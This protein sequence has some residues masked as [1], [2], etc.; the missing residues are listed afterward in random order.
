MG[1]NSLKENMSRSFHKVGFNLKKHSPE[2]LVVTGVIGG[3]ASAVLACRATTKANLVLADTKKKV[4]FINEGVQKGEVVGVMENGQEGVVKYSE[5]DGKNDLRIVYAKTGLEIAKLYAP[6]V[7]LG[8][9][10]VTSILAGHNILRKRN[11]AL[12]AAYATVDR[13]FKDYRKRVVERFGEDLDRELKYNIRKEEVEE[14]VTNED[15]TETKVKKTV[16]VVDSRRHSEYA[17]FFDET[18]RGWTKNAQNNKFFLM[19]T[20]DWANKKLRS[21]GYLFLNDVYE[22]LGA[23]KTKAG[24]AVGWLYDPERDDL[25]NQIDFFLFDVFDE[26]KRAFANGYERSVIVDFNVDGNIHNKM[27]VNTINLIEGF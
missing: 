6:A 1:M 26:R 10:S 23:M 17:I 15:G 2:I 18:C 14:T 4:E 25:E 20:Q 12:A 8:A 3:I 21:Q 22:M 27:D 16:D 11:V 7:I 19:Q 5:E 13:S 9:L 24:F